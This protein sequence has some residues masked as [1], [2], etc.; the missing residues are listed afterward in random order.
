MEDRRPGTGER[1]I[2]C[3]A[4]AF[5]FLERGQ[6]LHAGRPGFPFPLAISESL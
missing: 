1:E 3:L 2:L 4:W 5:F 6:S